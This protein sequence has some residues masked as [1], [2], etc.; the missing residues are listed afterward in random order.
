MDLN[1]LARGLAA[2]LAASEEAGCSAFPTAYDSCGNENYMLDQSFTHISYNSHTLVMGVQA[3][4]VDLP[5]ARAP[6]WL[7]EDTGA[8]EDIAPRAVGTVGNVGNTSN[9]NSLSFPLSSFEVG[10]R[11]ECGKRV[12]CWSR[13]GHASSADPGQD[14]PTFDERA[15]FLEYECGLTREQAEAQAR[16]EIEA[17]AMGSVADGLPPTDG[18]SLWRAGLA[19]LSPHQAPCPD[20]RSGM[21]SAVHARALAFLDAFG[22]QA[23]ALGWTASRLFGVHPE[24]GTVRVDYCGGLVLGVGGQVSAITGTE[25]QFGHLTHRTKPGQPAGVPIW[26][27][28]Q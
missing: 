13:P 10:K 12:S 18:L 2:G 15:A 21:W 16:A 1:A 8:R 26:R 24:I 11:E 14:G 25:I 17:A 4:H 7:P 3:G 5:A 20:Y 27:F 19:L 6:T 9:I 23:E 22:A 28:G